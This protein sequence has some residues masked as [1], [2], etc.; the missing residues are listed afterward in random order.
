MKLPGRAFYVQGPAAVWFQ[1]TL[2]SNRHGGNKAITYRKPNEA[3]E[4]EKT[5]FQCYNDVIT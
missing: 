2:Y 5:H 3:I 4:N 1:T